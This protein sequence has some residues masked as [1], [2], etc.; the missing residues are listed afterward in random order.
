M[1]R[2]SRIIC[3]RQR[4][5]LSE[6]SL[7]P[8]AAAV[9]H[10]AR[11]RPTVR[12]TRTTHTVVNRGNSPPLPPYKAGVPSRDQS[13]WFSAFFSCPTPTTS[14]QP[15]PPSVR[16]NPKWL[17]PIIF[18]LDR[19]GGPSTDPS[20]TW[21]MREHPTGSRVAPSAL[22]CVV[23]PCWVASTNK[24]GIP[25]TRPPLRERFRISS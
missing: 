15:P 13:R 1:R 4:R 5:M 10:R 16:A 11:V 24:K 18:R 7:P 22:D 19:G 12:D 8:Q 6:A 17:E 3:P 25:T 23:P 2:L 20:T 21:D 14:H 9:R